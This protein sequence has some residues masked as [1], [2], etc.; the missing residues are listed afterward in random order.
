MKLLGY[1]EVKGKKKDGS[2]FDF[3]NLFI[4]DEKVPVSSERGGSQIIYDYRYGFPSVSAAEFNQLA[5]DG[6]AVGGNI[7]VLRDWHGRLVVKI[8]K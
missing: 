6:L 2:E 8:P 4:E 3:Y 5:H 1:N 7:E